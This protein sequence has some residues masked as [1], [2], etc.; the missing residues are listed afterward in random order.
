MKKAL[1]LKPQDPLLKDGLV[2]IPGMRHI[3]KRLI[4]PGRP[5][6]EIQAATPEKLTVETDKF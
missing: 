5:L 3:S 1:W 2:G 6:W 4:R